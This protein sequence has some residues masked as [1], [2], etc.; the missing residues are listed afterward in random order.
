[1]KKTNRNFEILAAVVE[2]ER[3]LKARLGYMVKTEKAP[4]AAELSKAAGMSEDYLYKMLDPDSENRLRFA[5][6]DTAARISTEVATRLHSWIGH[7]WGLIAV[8]GGN[9]LD[10]ILG[11][12]EQAGQAQSTLAA[13]AIDGVIDA[14]ERQQALAALALLRLRVDAVEAELLAQSGD[15]PVPLRKAVVQ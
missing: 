9:P 15:A 13:A 6:V 7:R 1:M 3:E 12:V 8:A 11:L 10:A 2:D 14:K 4:S 5:V